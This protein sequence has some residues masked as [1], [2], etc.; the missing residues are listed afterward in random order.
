VCT[1]LFYKNK[2]KS[3][4]A[5]RQNASYVFEKVPDIY[6]QFDSAE[7][8]FECTKRPL[9]MN[10][11]VLWALYGKDIFANKIEYLCQLTQEAYQ[12]LQQEPDFQT[13]HQP[14]VNILCFRYAPSNVSDNLLSDFQLAIRNRIR[15]GGKFFISKVEIDGI[16]S[17]RVVF[18][19]HRINTNH[20][21]ELLDEIRKIGLELISGT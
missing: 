15:E 12:I 17:L 19:N 1:L 11:W 10:L 9:I 5:F 6:T 14:E 20:F 16:N 4:E 13:I 18:M 3:Y 8:N 2:E 7:Q 21:H